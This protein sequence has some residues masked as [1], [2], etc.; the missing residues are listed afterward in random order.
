MLQ[1]ATKPFKQELGVFTVLELTYN[2]LCKLRL[3]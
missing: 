3:V 1:K 2:V